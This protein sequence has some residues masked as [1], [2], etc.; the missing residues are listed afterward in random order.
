MS[1]RNKAQR[2]LVQPDPV[3]NQEKN[4]LLKQLCI[5]R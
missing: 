3:Y 4:R 5:T 1:R 2:A